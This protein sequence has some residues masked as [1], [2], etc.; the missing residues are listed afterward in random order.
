V[1]RF[2]RRFFKTANTMTLHGFPIDQ[3]HF[4]GLCMWHLVLSF[5]YLI[6]IEY[7]RSIITGL[8][9]YKKKEIFQG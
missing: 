7:S 2:M 8:L 1:R 6:E 3:K 5:S 4:L 9:L